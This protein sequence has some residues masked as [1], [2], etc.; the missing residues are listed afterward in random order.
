[1]ITTKEIS[2]LSKNILQISSN[3]VNPHGS[4]G[5]LQLM[6]DDVGNSMNSTNQAIQAKD[7]KK[8]DMYLF[9]KHP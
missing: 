5:G 2:L 1:M 3:I 6:S 8:E 9:S 7:E 4:V